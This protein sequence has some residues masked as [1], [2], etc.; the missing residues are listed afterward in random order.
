MCLNG[1]NMAQ[2]GPEAESDNVAW[3]HEWTKKSGNTQNKNFCPMGVR[4]C[5]SEGGTVFMVHVV[6]LF[7]APFTVEQ[8]VK[9]VIR[10]V[11]YEKVNYQLTRN[12]PE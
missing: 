2:N 7:V 9:P 6:N 4:S 8:P 10:V 1:F 3:N 12:L 11:L 5:K